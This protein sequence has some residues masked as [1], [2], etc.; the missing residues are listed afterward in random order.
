M[1]FIFIAACLFNPPPTPHP[2]SRRRSWRGFRSRTVQFDRQDFH[3]RC[4]QLH[5]RARTKI[6]GCGQRE[7]VL[8]VNQS[9]PLPAVRWIVLL[10]DLELEPWSIRMKIGVGGAGVNGVGDNRGKTEA[11]TIA[12]RKNSGVGVALQLSTPNVAVARN[13]SGDTG[14]NVRGVERIGIKIN[15]ENAALLT[16]AGKLPRDVLLAESA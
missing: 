16:V 12:I 13:C 7:S 3:L 9:A 4:C 1:R 8:H 10:A 15:V 5:W 11:E 6:S 14:E 2:A